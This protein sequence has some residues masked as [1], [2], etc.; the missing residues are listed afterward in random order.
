MKIREIDIGDPQGK[1]E[2]QGY[3]V[4]FRADDISNYHG[5]LDGKPL[6]YVCNTKKEICEIAKEF[7]CKEI[8]TVHYPNMAT[9]TIVIILLKGYDHS[10]H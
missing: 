1:Q 6:G 2:G 9:R 10:K 3:I 4:T 5:E 7:D 8:R